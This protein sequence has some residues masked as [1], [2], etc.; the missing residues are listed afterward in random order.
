MVHFNMPACSKR[1]R[2]GGMG[3]GDIPT[4]GLACTHY[5]RLHRSHINHQWQL[6]HCVHLKHLKVVTYGTSRWNTHLVE[7]LRT[8]YAAHLLQYREETMNLSALITWASLKAS[9]QLQ[10]IHLCLRLIWLA[11]GATTLVS[12]PVHIF[13]RA[14]TCLCI[15]LCMYCLDISWNPYRCASGHTYM[16]C[17]CVHSY[18]LDI[19]YWSNSQVALLYHTEIEHLRIV[20]VPNIWLFLTR[21]LWTAP[22]DECVVC[23][24]NVKTWCFLPCGHKVCFIHVSFPHVH[25]ILSF[26]FP[27]KHHRSN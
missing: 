1:E 7:T 27:K 5:S 17:F 22:S 6:P 21:S 15:H 8:W 2:V 23:M 25:L 12:H 24:S 10:V 14:Y 20:F 4:A 9:P 19:Y 11:C 13:I 3:R 26:Y 16:H 18:A